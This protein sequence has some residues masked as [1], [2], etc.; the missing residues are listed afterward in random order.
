MEN[1][2]KKRIAIACQGG[3]SHGAFTWGVL[4]ALLEDGRFEIEGLTGTSAGGMNAV[5]TAQGLAKGGNKE[6]RATLRLFWERVHESGKNS[7]LN[8]RGPIDKYMHNWT[9]YN[10]PGFLMFEFLSRMYSPYE[11]NPMKTDPLRD[12]IVNTFDFD[13]L[14]SQDVCKVFLCAT[15]VYT[16]KLAVF[17]TNEIKLECLLAT[18]CLP[19]IH[20]AVLVDGEYYWDGGFIGNPVM[21]PLIYDCETSDVILIQ[22]NPAIRNKLPTSA[23]EISDRLNEIT[24]NASVIRE[25]RAVHLI[26]Q[27]Q[28]EGIIPEGRMK[29]VHMHLIEDEACFQELGWG[30][31]LNTEMDFFDHLFKKGRDAATAWISKN[32]ESVGKKTTA[33]IREHFTGKNWD[34]HA[35][36]SSSMKMLSKKKK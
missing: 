17:K 6:A 20:G 4:D 25:M 10:S 11:L 13:F 36:H 16:G 26:G 21:F 12:V 29:R 30:S 8:N 9:M 3:G 27:L 23:R 1:K 28:D 34:E 18:A 32:Y 22:V 35:S 7:I 31:K 2:V 14:R 15:H 24:N 19:T 5:A 33:L